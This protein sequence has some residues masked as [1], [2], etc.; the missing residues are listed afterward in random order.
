MRTWSDGAFALAAD[1][2]RRAGTMLLRNRRGR[3]SISYKSGFG[4][5]VT[6]MD[7]ASEAMILRAIRRAFP[8]HAIVAEESGRHAGAD[9]RWFVDPLDGTTN[10]AHGLPI[11]AVSIGFERGGVMEGGVV[12][13]PPLDDLWWARRGRGAFRNR[14]RL[15]VSATRDLAKA[16]L[17]T[18][19]PYAMKPKVRNLRHWDAFLRRARAV[20]R[21]GSA[22]LD[23][24][25]TAAGI[26]D[27]FWEGHLGPWDIAAGLLLCSEAGATLTD[28]SGGPVDL[29]TGEVVAANRAIHRQMLAVL[30]RRRI[31]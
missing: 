12:Y 1:I 15:R 29:F 21:L 17:C 3:R 18:G 6:E 31:Y 7:R 2:A 8:D 14:E 27:G 28:Y 25:F 23:L 11:Y 26:Y 9:V 5:L 19:F 24:C 13:H 22:S 10:Y 16:L 30:R 4:N 20:R